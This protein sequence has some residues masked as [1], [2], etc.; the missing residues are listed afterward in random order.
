MGESG[1]ESNSVKSLD[2]SGSFCWK[3]EEWV[4]F[5]QKWV[6]VNRFCWKMGRC[7]SFLSKKRWE[8]VF[9]ENWVRVGHSCWN[10]SRIMSF[11]SKNEW[12]WVVFLGKLVRMSHFSWK[13]SGSGW[14]LL[15]VTGRGWEWLGVGESRWEWLVRQFGKSRK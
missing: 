15:E 5:V 12:L 9:L 3:I 1:W 13:M 4:D 2:G 11:L 14:E 10:K 8:W 7:V 6:G